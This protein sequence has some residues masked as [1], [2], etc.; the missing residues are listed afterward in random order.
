MKLNRITFAEVLPGLRLRMRFA[1]GFTGT[2]PLADT[3]RIGGALATVRDNPNRFSVAPG[4]R[5]VVWIDAA[6]D[7]VD[8]CADALRLLA[9]GTVSRAAE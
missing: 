1:D 2:A 6:G 5:A 4:G 7:E 8:L 9:E 3:V